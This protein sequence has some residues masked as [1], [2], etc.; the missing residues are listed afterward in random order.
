M[1]S[2]VTSQ[3]TPWHQYAGSI[4]DVGRACA[5]NS[6]TEARRAYVIVHCGCASPQVHLPANTS[7]MPHFPQHKR[8]RMYHCG[9]S[10]SWSHR[11]HAYGSSTVG[12]FCSRFVN[13]RM[14]TQAF[15]HFRVFRP[16][17]PSAPGPVVIPAKE[18]GKG[19]GI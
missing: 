19:R 4:F 16:N 3:G 12:P 17:F 8:L 7:S 1:V 2:I 11:G 14:V 9:R 10:C 18:A 15:A 5:S 13:T 6:C